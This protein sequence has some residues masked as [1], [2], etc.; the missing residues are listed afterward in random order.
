VT[1]FLT[2]LNYSLPTAFLWVV[3]LGFGLAILLNARDQVLDFLRGR[4]KP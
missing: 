1:D 2:W 4:R 3:G